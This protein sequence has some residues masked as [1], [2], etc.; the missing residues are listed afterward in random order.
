MII[1]SV[2]RPPDLNLIVF[3]KSLRTSLE[4]IYSD[5][6]DLVI[7]GDFTTNVNNGLPNDLRSIALEYSLEQL[8]NDYTRISDHSKTIIDLL[9]VSCSHKAVQ[10]GVIHPL[11]S[12]HFLIFCVIKGGVKRV[13][14]KQFEYRCFKNYSKAAFVND[15]D[16]VP[17]SAIKGVDDIDE[18]VFMWEYLFS[19]VADSHAPIKFMRKGTKNPWVTRDLIKMQYDKHYYFK[20]GQSNK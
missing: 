16:R 14:P 8:I 2:Y 20:K 17:C 12:D 1:G 3:A 5:S 10:A 6:C 9:F 11:I 19:E 4:L 15:L 13:P 7:L 18:Q